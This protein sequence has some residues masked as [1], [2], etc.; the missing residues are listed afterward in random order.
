MPRFAAN[1]SLMFNE[2][3]FME[4]FASAAE[5]GF[6]GVEYLFPYAFEPAAI[7]AEL[8][9]HRLQQVLFNLPPGD[10]EA[11][12]RGIAALPGREAE[13]RASVDT[14]LHYAEVLECRQLH[15]MAGV[16]P[17]PAQR[18]VMHECWLENLAWAAP[19]L[20]SAGITLLIEAINHRDMPGYLINYQQQARDA[21]EMLGAPNIRMQMDFYHAQIMEG[22]LWQS[23]QQHRNQV[24]HL[25]V[26][27]VPERH[28]PDSG[29][30]NYP[31]LFEQL[32]QAGY[33]GWIGCEYRPWHETSAGLKWFERWREQQWDSWQ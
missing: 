17:E 20:E 2:V 22:D 18:Q 9:R 7:A 19:R 33:S 29:E 14:A 1:L 30:V 6:R 21:I 8:R 5:Q 4:R 26:A 28:E 16:A 25:Q 27:S 10:W 32:D 3:P 13:F 24:G 12:E 11:G 31:W 23:W 15:I